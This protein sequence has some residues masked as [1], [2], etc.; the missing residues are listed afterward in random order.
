MSVDATASDSDGTIARVDFYRG[1]TLIGSD[2]SS[3]Y[4]VTWSNAP[5]GSYSLTAVAVDDDGATTT[6]AARSVTVSAANAAP[7]VSLIAP[8]DGAVFTAP[9]NISIDATA[10]D[11]DGT[12]SRV[13]FYRGTTLIGSDS[14]SPYNFIW[15]GVPAG[16]YSLTAV[17]VDDDGASTT[18]AGRAVTVNVPANQPPAV[19][20]D[21]P[22][23]GNSFTAPANVTLSA[24][25]SDADGTVVRVDF[26]Q[27]TTLI[28]SDTTN[29]YTV[30]WTNVPAGTYSLTAA[31]TDN[32]G[33]TT[34]SSARSVTV[35]EA[36]PAG[37]TAADIGNPAVAG[38]TSY[39][40]GVFT[41]RGAGTDIWLT[42]DEFHYVYQQVSG[43]FDVVARVASVEAVTQYSKA[44]V[45]I[46]ES[47]TGS[48][49]NAALMMPAGT[50]LLMFQTRAVA[51]ATA[52]RINVT[53]GLP[54]WTKLER[55]GNVI[56]AHSSLDG[57]VWTV[58]GSQTLTLPSSV[59]V[60]LVVT[61]TDVSRAA[62][63]E[64]DNVAVTAVN[65]LPAVSLTAPADGAT[66]TAPASMT[67]SA[68]ASDSDGTVA[69]VDFYHGT[70][71]VGTDTTSPYSITWSSVPAGSYS[72]TAVAVDDDGAA[73][74]SAA[75]II[76]VNAPNAAPTVSLT[77]PAN[78][79]TYTAPATLILDANAS[80]SDGTIARVD[81]YRGTTLIGSDSA[82]PYSFTWGG[83]AAGSYSLTAVAVDD[84]GATTTSA[85]RSVTVNAPNTAPSV[86]LTAPA[87]GAT[88]TAPATI[89]LNATASDSDGTIARVD[90]Y[91]GTTLVGS[92]TASPFSV[93]WSNVPV[94]SYSLTAVAT[95]DDGAATTSA[96]R[97]ITVNAPPNQPPAVSL[98]APANGATYNA[99]ASIT[100][101]ATA[102]DSDGT[103][104]RVDFYQGTT[105][106][107][108]DTT[109]PHSVT[110]NSVPAGS[111]SLTA[112]AVDDD[113]AATTSAART[114]T[115]NFVDTAPPTAP[116]TLSASAS[117]SSQIGLAWS[118]SS[119]NVGVAQYRVE[120]CQGASCSAFSQVGT[121]TTTSYTDS[122]LTPATSYSYRVRAVDATGNLGAYSPTGTAVTSAAAAIAFV[123]TRN[124][125]P[126]TP[127]GTVT[128][129]YNGAQ[130]AGN[131]NV[132]VIGWD[133]GTSQVA[134]VSD[135]RGNSYSAA[136][137]IT[138]SPG[139][140]SIVTYY[141]AG[142]AAASSNSNTVTVTFST[143]VPYPDVRILEYSGVD[144]ASPV[145]GTVG[146]YGSGT[147]SN[148]GTLTV[149]TSPALLVA[150]NTVSSV[151][152]AAGSGF[153]SR[154]ITSPN[155]GIAED[156]VAATTGSYNATA[157]LSSG[158]W[159]TQM[160][161]FRAASAAPADTQPPSAPTAL[162]A[163][164]SGATQ[165]ALSWTA[166]TDNVGVT[167][168]RVERC[169]GVGCIAFAQVG[170]STT[171]TYASTGLIPGT[172]YTYRVRAAD[173]A[174]NL[175]AYS[176]FASATTTADTQS[177]TAPTTLTTSA[178][179]TNQLTL[180]WTAAH[181]NIGVTEYRVERCQG[182][183]CS[184]FAQVG[185]STTTSYTNTG[186]SAATSY[187][188]RVRAVDASG[189]VGPFSPTAT[190]MTAAVP[191]TRT[192]YWAPSPDHNTLVTSY[193][194]EVYAVGAT[195][196]VNTPL[197]S[198]SLGKPA[199]VDSECSADV[200]A[201]INALTPGNYQIVLG[202]VGS[203]GTGRGAAIPFT[204]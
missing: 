70:T 162:T 22:V 137:P 5:A 17:A 196:G 126:Q 13:D 128:V 30:S 91:Q 81:F 43:D 186:L 50:G 129:T 60:G 139:A 132:V 92:D 86:S 120:R 63:A 152:T 143:P 62:Q 46:R 25:A 202:A 180:S 42:A 156:R 198:Q 66:Y 4:S 112:V 204:R 93:T 131:L 97:A 38:S 12:V 165:I 144:S 197:A 150:G 172:S 99:P 118:A 18:S 52:E 122:G 117:S 78:G 89:A 49:A 16:S 147:T 183:G 73:A 104:G 185:T 75:R 14:T 108:S 153:T 3:P 189:N 151:T 76:T 85:P 45:M 35:A 163:N 67:V 181:D 48:A 98:T 100:M 34:T 27:G 178:I 177:P 193:V 192:A 203:G 179:G 90:F 171:T 121:S 51:G 41:I 182:V 191:T 148:T 136:G 201:T 74:T 2:T 111:Y 69:R 80:D 82:S 65:Q 64:L 57:S 101:S 166:A 109:S 7:S 37:W 28:G 187:S 58:V 133:D 124:S 56:T 106:I 157:T 55:R 96:A 19:V 145:L 8:A 59:F 107:G 170:T 174:G 32:A 161:A 123:Q 125:V 115:V 36:L 119:D 71:L 188:F 127:Q 6:S 160:V 33:A 164:A 47:L 169:A 116:A 77:A 138:R 9:A 159:V 135:S 200:T 10:T 146:A 61:S 20:L 142:I 140:R 26:Y 88:Y 23:G 114:V 95:D 24:T 110:W 11:A 29:P 113:G 173:A 194:M 94:G 167:E 79:A 103:I 39:S 176:S 84:G 54:V 15:S 21:E 68:S 199:V 195:P 31:A 44:G 168:Y 134:N 83:V 105:L 158:N 72:L 87:N 154:V 155:G 130:T 184:V 40:G 175:G 190:A 1:T 141:S 149:A 102:T 53:A